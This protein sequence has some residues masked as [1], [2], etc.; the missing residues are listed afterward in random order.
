M[1]RQK[2]KRS[3]PLT[4]S[5]IESATPVDKPIRLFDGGGLY[6]EIVP[7]GGKW[8]RLKYRFRGK[9][10]RLAFGTYPDVTMSDARKQREAAKT[11][12]AQGID[13]GVVRSEQK[14]REIA[15]RLGKENASKVHV[16]FALDGGV[17]IWKGRA[18]V[19]LRP[20]EAQAV[21]DLLT[22]MSA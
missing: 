5:E 19:N 10:K 9:E 4:V 17:E 1:A 14:A 7:T 15:D 13:P 22:K 11:L 16:A 8:W 21:K 12:L 20:D 6:L 3:V 18:V 2:S